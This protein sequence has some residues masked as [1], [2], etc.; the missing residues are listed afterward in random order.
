MLLAGHAIERG[1]LDELDDAFAYGEGGRRAFVR[2]RAGAGEL[3]DAASAQPRRAGGAHRAQARAARG[4]E[5]R[6]LRKLA[7]RSAAPS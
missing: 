4:R 1:L 7:K 6:D 3:D 5:R 2:L